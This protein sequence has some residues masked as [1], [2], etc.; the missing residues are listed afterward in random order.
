MGWCVDD[1]K[2][3]DAF[4][5][6]LGSPPV[7]HAAAA[8]A[9]AAAT[10]SRTPSRKVRERIPRQQGAFIRGPI[11]LA[12]LDGVFMIPGATALRVA[13]ALCY[14]SGLEG[15]STV[16]F[17]HKLMVMFRIGA[18]SAS[19]TLERMQA[20]GLVRVRHRSG[21]CREVEILKVQSESGNSTCAN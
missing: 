3:L 5:I 18:R 10:G 19:R 14:Q 13:L 16:R 4:R 20:A 15:S 1:E 7:A 21:S 9:P 12:W 8:T 6:P 11:L 17:T 2:E